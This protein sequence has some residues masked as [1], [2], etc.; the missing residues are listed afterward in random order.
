[1]RMAANQKAEGRLYS[2]QPGASSIYTIPT[3]LD[4]EA[5]APSVPPNFGPLPHSVAA[6]YS[7]CRPGYNQPAPALLAGGSAWN[8]FSFG[9]RSLA[10]VPGIISKPRS[11]CTSMVFS[12]S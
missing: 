1:M 9:V 8:G 3:G 2:D 10:P 6:A 5:P 4:Q 12:C 11:N 7:G